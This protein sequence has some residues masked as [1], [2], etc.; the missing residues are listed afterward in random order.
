MFSDYI[1]IS[2]PAIKRYRVNMV[3]VVMLQAIYIMQNYV[4]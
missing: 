2:H 4:L 1:D 3:Q